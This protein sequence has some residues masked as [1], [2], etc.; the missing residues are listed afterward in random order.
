PFGTPPHSGRFGGDLNPPPTIRFLWREQ[1]AHFLPP[2]MSNHH[3]WPIVANAY[4]I[5]LRSLP[6]DL[7]KR[8][9]WLPSNW[10]A[11]PKNINWEKG[12]TR[13]EM[14]GGGS[15]RV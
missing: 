5:T 4:M 8:L 3:I 1:A 7:R 12:G 9:T 2:Y 15:T 11:A 10:R 6:D 13:Y 14:N